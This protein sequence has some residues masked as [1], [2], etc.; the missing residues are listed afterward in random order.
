M[1]K[2]E[3]EDRNDD[4]G[5]NNPV[6]L[7]NTTLRARTCIHQEEVGRRAF[8]VPAAV[9]TPGVPTALEFHLLHPLPL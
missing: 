9:L 2:I 7:P 3:W 5:D 1:A 4:L 8:T 6:N